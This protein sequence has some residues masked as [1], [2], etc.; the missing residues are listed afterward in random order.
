MLTKNSIAK[1]G[2]D[3]FRNHTKFNFDLSVIVPTCNE[4]GN[5]HAL[6]EHLDQVL[7]GTH[8]EVLFVD[9]S[10]DETP[11]V[12]EAAKPLFPELTIRLFHRS[13]SRTERVG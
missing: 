3:L 7:T 9:D 6:L 12:V 10:T 8:A 13:A 4:A 11:Q 2:L 5:V 1:T